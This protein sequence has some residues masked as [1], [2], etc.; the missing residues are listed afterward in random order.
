MNFDDL[1]IATIIGGIGLTGAYFRAEYLLW[2]KY[3]AAE[4]QKEANPVPGAEA[5]YC[6]Q[7]SCGPGPAT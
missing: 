4:R 5:R 2:R 7:A 3:K 1:L 6:G